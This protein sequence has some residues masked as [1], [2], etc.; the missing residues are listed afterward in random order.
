MKPYY[1]R[2]G[3]TLYCG[4]CRDVLPT[5]D[6]CET[7]LTDPPYGLEFMGKEWD[8]LNLWAKRDKSEDLTG[9]SSRP[10][11]AAAVNKYVG[12][13]D[14]QRWFTEMFTAIH[15]ATRLEEKNHG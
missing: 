3:I 9:K 4:D 6:P 13:P 11:L 5:L 14:A 1:Q 8:K 12:G 15:A 7:C 10:F 2:D